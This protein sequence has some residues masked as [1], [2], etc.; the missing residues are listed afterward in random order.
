[1]FLWRSSEAPRI[2]PAARRPYVTVSMSDYMLA[3][4]PDRWRVNHPMGVEPVMRTVFT[5]ELK[6]DI[7]VIEDERRKAF[8]DLVIAASRQIYGQAAML[9]KGAPT[10]TISSASR[11]GKEIY[12]VFPSEKTEDD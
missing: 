1:M 6:C 2:G 8:I 9:A 3:I 5:I 4:T 11:N 12:P 10:I 7:D